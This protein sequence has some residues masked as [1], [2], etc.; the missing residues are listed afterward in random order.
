MYKLGRL[1]R[2]VQFLGRRDCFSGV[3]GQQRRNFQGY[4]SVDALGFVMDPPKQVGGARQI[5]DRQLEENSSPD[6]P[7]FTLSAMADRTSRLF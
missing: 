2:A 6:R 5:L 1:A 7:S 4:P 3:I